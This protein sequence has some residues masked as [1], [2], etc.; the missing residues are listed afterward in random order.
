MNDLFKDYNGQTYW[1]SFNPVS[2][3]NK[4]SKIP[5][6]INVSLG[7]GINNQLIGDG[8]TF[9][10]NY[11]GQQI[12]FAPYRQYYLS[13]DLDWE[14]IEVDSKLLKLLFRGLN[15]V[16]LPFPAIEFSKN[17]VKGHALYF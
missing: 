6:W 16:K 11:G 9:V 12:S 8:G 2:M 7:Y 10:T 14:K 17:G 4:E 15:V 1:L 13:L 5:K 3:I